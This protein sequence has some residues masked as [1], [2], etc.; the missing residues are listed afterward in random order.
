MTKHH[1]RDLIWRAV[2][3]GDGQ[4]LDLLAE[5]LSDATRSR[6]ILRA[7]GYGAIGMPGSATAAQVPDAATA[8]FIYRLLTPD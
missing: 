4:Q 7:K 1:Y 5:Q 3:A 6:E 2:M 8:S